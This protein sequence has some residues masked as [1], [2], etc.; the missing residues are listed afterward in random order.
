MK[1]IKTGILLLLCITL[2]SGC[3]NRFGLRNPGGP[4]APAPQTPPIESKIGP[5]YMDFPDVLVPGE[6]KRSA[7]ECYLSNG[8]GRLVLSGRV[9][10]ESLATFFKSGMP[11]TGWQ[12]LDEY[13]YSGA[14]KL[15]FAK[16]DKIASVLIMENPM[17][18]K[19]EIWVTPLKPR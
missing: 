2:L 18:T 15:F 3:A 4:S 1:G 16:P 19:V 6:L 11:T 17:D 8:F 14:T 12:V 7:G 5:V 9:E 10:G 13:K